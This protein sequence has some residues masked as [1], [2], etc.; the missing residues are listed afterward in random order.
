M[1]SAQ[2]LLSRSFCGLIL[3]CGGYLF[4]QDSPSDASADASPEAIRPAQTPPTTPGEE[5]A[6]PDKRVFGV[7]P[8]YRTVDDNT[9][10]S[11]ITA[12]KKLTIATKDTLDYPLF[13]VGAGF[14]GLAQITNQHPDFGQGMKGYAHRYATAYSDQAIGNYMTEGFLPVLFHEDPRYFRIGSTRG[15]VWYRAGYAA[16]RIFVTKT[17]RGRTTFNFAEVVGNSI[18]AGVGNAYYPSE[19]RL[20][21]NA[22]RLLTALATDAISQV[23]KEFWPDIKRKYFSHHSGDS[24]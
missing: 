6:A 1:V 9:E 17:D 15:G 16:S 19:R 18:A 3:L 24:H 2:K 20:G 14:A 10:F 11:P 4:A 13:L 21:D 8:N 23:L 22:E 7:L 5:S 12:K